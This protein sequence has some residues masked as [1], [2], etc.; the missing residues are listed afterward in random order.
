MDPY[1]AFAKENYNLAQKLFS[2]Q[3]EKTTHRNHHPLVNNLYLA[4]YQLDK[5]LNNLISSLNDL[6]RDKRYSTE[7]WFSLYIVHS[8]L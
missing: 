8:C 2:L 1:K 4:Q 6:L 3:V 7:S 5:D